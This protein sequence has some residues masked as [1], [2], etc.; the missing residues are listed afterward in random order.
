MQEHIS[1]PLAKEI[2]EKYKILGGEAPKAKL[3]WAQCDGGGWIQLKADCVDLEELRDLH[4]CRWYWDYSAIELF[5]VLPSN[6]HIWKDESLGRFHCTRLE[7]RHIPV[8]A[9]YEYQ[10]DEGFYPM[11]HADTAAETLGLM[12]CRV[13]DERIREQTNQGGAR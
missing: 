4:P 8:S 13:L 11:T 6:I 3:I 12:W 1:F 9:F 2:A 10:S 5:S 7:I